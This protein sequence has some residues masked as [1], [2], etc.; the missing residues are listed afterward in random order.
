M[1]AYQTDQ[2]QEGILLTA[3]ISATGPVYSRAIILKVDEPAQPGIKVADSQ[4][5]D[6]T[7]KIKKALIGTGSKLKGYRL[8]VVSQVGVIGSTKQ[9]RLDNAKHAA[10][11]YLLQT[12]DGNKVSYN[13]PVITTT[14]NGDDVY[15]FIVF[16]VDL[17]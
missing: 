15:V 8:G 11:D 1:N 2:S 12:G 13:N 3:S 7:G 10:G 4:P 6:H 9:E 14:E 17:V 16:T 5:M